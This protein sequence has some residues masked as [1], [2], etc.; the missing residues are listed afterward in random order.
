MPTNGNAQPANRQDIE[1]ELAALQAEDPEAYAAIADLIMLLRCSV[2]TAAEVLE[3]WYAS[4]PPSL[5]TC[6]AAAENWVN[7]QPDNAVK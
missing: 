6:F 1:A 3:G 4:L 7:N 5:H 2:W